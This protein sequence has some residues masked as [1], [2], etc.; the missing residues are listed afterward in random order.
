MPFRIRAGRPAPRP[1]KSWT[2]TLVGK[3]PPCVSKRLSNALSKRTALRDLSKV[4]QSGQKAK[5]MEQMKWGKNW[6]GAA[7]LSTGTEHVWHR[8]NLAGSGLRQHLRRYPVTALGKDLSSRSCFS[9]IY[10]LGQPHSRQRFIRATLNHPAPRA[11]REG[12]L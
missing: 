6:A 1:T 10:A 8:M 11:F 3:P 12:G 2:T 7:S 9:F 4:A 5:E